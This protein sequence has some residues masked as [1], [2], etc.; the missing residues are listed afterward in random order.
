[1]SPTRILILWTAIGVA[2][3]LV[4]V[5]ASAWNEARDRRWVEEQMDKRGM[6]NCVQTGDWRWDCDHGAGMMLAK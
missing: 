2:F 4:I 1:M 5:G 6:T 3:V